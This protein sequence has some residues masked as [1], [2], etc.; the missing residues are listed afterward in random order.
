MKQPVNLTSALTE[1][2]PP[3][4]SIYRISTEAYANLYE[5]FV[6]AVVIA[7]NPEQAARQLFGSF[8]TRADVEILGIAPIRTPPHIVLRYVLLKKEQ[9]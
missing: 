3:K 7:P 9:L 1:V 8:A 2:T 5:E 6:D 4:M